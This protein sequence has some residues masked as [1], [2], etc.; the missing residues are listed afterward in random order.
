MDAVAALVP[1]IKVLALAVLDDGNSG[2]VD[3][4]PSPTDDPAA[5]AVPPPAVTAP[6]TVVPSPCPS[7]ACG[8][9]DNAGTQPNPLALNT[10]A[11]HDTFMPIFETPR[12]VIPTTLPS[13]LSSIPTA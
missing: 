5:L 11:T 12:Q 2:P 13:L 6:P 1:P 4:V 9:G 8:N 7:I 3:T 10:T